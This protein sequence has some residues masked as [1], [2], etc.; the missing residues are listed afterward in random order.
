MFPADKTFGSTAPFFAGKKKTCRLSHEYIDR[1]RLFVDRMPHG[2][3][4]YAGLNRY[5]GRVP[6]PLPPVHICS[7]PMLEM[8]ATLARQAAE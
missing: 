5:F 1:P 3:S 8:V 6:E 4:F 7:L 2:A